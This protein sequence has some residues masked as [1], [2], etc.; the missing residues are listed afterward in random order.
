MKQPNLK[1]SIHEN[2]NN[3]EVYFFWLKFYG[4]TCSISGSIMKQVSTE[5]L[6]DITYKEIDLDKQ[7]S[8]DFIEGTNYR[9]K[10]VL[11]KNL[12]TGYIKKSNIRE[13]IAYQT[14]IEDIIEHFINE[15]NH[16]ARK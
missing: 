9:E 1:N 4:H 3:I 8:S 15:I 16:V 5:I 2:L 6:P 14:P 12:K 7:P 10:I 11:I 13:L